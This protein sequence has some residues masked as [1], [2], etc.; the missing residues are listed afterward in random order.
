MRNEIYRHLVTY[1]IFYSSMFYLH[2]RFWYTS[3]MCKMSRNNAALRM[4]PRMHQYVQ[5]ETQK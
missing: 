3:I 4:A 1:L 5:L 2:L